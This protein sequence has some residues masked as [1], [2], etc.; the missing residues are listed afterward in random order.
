[1]PVRRKVFRIEEMAQAEAPDLMPAATGEFAM[2]HHVT[3]RE[4]KALRAMVERRGAPSEPE[5]H[6]NEVQQLKSELQ[7][8]YETVKNTMQEFAAL[9]AAGFEG[10]QMAGVTNELGAVVGSAENATQRILTAAETIDEHASTLSAGLRSD[11]QLGLAQDIQDGVVRIFE[12][13]VFHDLTGQRIAK[14]TAALKV[15]EDHVGRMITIWGGPDAFAEFIP[16]ASKLRATCPLI[17]GPRLGDE[18]DHVDQSGID[19]IF[20]AFRPT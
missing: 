18:T 16:A 6:M 1:M 2:C 11:H 4:L 13:C 14:V 3:L 5:P 7:Q 8:L 19:A 20:A 15:V 12:A 17:N 10:G 9:H